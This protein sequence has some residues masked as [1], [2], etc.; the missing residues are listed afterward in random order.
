MNLAGSSAR[1]HETITVYGIGLFQGLALV[2][3]PAAATILPSE[4]EYDL[5]KSQY[6]L[7][8]LPQDKG[9]ARGFDW[10]AGGGHSPPGDF[11]EL[12]LGGPQGL[13]LGDFMP[14]G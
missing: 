10:G 2:A 9:G 5:S 14:S 12:G 11:C 7:L 3:F 4:S 6:G 8:F 13:G 1:R